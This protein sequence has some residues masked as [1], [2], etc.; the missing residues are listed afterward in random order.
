MLKE[1]CACGHINIEKRAGSRKKERF[2]LQ[3]ENGVQCI[4]WA[5]HLCISI[6]LGLSSDGPV[7]VGNG[8]YCGEHCGGLSEVWAQDK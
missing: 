5:H 8:I 2:I 3:G 1:L 7:S 4:I 6:V